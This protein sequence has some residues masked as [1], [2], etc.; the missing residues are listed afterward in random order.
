MVSKPKRHEPEPFGVE[1][2]SGFRRE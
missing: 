1:G 2:G